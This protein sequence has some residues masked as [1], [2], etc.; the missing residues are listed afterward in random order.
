MPERKGLYWIWFSPILDEAPVWIIAEWDG[1]DWTTETGCVFSYSVP[2]G[3]FIGD[4][5]AKPSGPPEKQ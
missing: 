1:E 3:P 5:S 4:R 2:V